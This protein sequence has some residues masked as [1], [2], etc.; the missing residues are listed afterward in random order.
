ME[1][2]K[3]KTLRVGIVGYGFMGKVHTYSYLNLPF[4]YETLPVK[5]KMVGVCSNLVSYG[6]NDGCELFV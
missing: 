5:I 3:V 2:K 1:A 6:S 4:F